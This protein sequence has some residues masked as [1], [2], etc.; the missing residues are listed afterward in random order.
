[1]RHSATSQWIYAGCIM[2]SVADAVGYD[3]HPVFRNY[4]H[5]GELKPSEDA[6]L[7]VNSGSCL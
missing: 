6:E 2:C 7:S 1:M 5:F 3:F 4:R